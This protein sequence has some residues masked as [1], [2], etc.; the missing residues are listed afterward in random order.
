MF[1]TELILVVFT[2]YLTFMY[3]I[4]F[5]FFSVY[6]F[7][8][9][10]AYNFSQGSTYLMFLG[11]IVGLLVVLA[12]TPLW[13]KLLGYEFAKASKAGL[14][15]PPPEAMLWWAMCGALA[16]PIA[17]FSMSWSAMPNVLY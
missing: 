9:G 10:N 2:L 4:I 11:I 3:I 12:L 1:L 14:V 17:M 5:S 7:I 13:G 16:V 8:F 15:H 6:P